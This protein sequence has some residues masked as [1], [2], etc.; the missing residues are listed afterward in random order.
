MECRHKVHQALTAN[1]DFGVLDH[2]LPTRLTPT[3]KNKEQRL[4]V[5]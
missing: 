5:I 3:A 1:P 2:L 4:K